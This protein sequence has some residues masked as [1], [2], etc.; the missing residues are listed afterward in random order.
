MFMKIH[1]MLGNLISTSDMN[2]NGVD[3]YIS[4]PSKTI[5]IP[6]VI[7]RNTMRSKVT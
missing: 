7:L 3:S 4:E 6:K 5:K 1:I 2:Y